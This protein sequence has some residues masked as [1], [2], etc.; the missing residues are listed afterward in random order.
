M[1]KKKTMTKSKTVRSKS[2]PF[3]DPLNSF[4]CEDKQPFG[5]DETVAVW[6]NG[7]KGPSLSLIE[8]LNLLSLQGGIFYGVFID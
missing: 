2:W 8:T 6:Y 1:S 4:A 3:H 5:R 7:D